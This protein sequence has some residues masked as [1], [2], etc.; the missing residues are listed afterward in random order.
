MHLSVC[1]G[2]VQAVIMSRVEFSVVTLVE[3][4]RSL[5]SFDLAQNPAREG[6]VKGV[7]VGLRCI[8]CRTAEHLR[9]LFHVSTKQRLQPEH[10]QSAILILRVP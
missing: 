3:Q 7:A 10:R 5:C 8:I 6:Q 1:T 9:A 2:D 4:N